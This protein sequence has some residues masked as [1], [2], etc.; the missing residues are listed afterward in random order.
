MNSG[1]RRSRCSRAA[2][3]TPGPVRSTRRSSVT[4]R[5]CTCSSPA[6]TGSIYRAS[7]PIGNFPGSFGSNY[8]TIMSDTQANL[9]EARGGLQGQG[10]EPVPDDR[11]GDG[12]AAGGTSARSR[13]PASAARGRRR[14]PA[15]A[16]RSRARPTAAR[17]GPTTS[18]TVTWSG[19]NPDQT[20]TIDPCNLQLLYQGRDPNVEP[21]LQQPALPAGSADP[22]AVVLSTSKGR[23]PNG[24]PALCASSPSGWEREGGLGS[25]EPASD[26][27]RSTIA[28]R[29][30]DAGP[31]HQPP[32]RA[33]RDSRGRGPRPAWSRSPA[34]R[35]PDAGGR[36]RWC[37]TPP[38]LRG[39]VT[40]PCARTGGVDVTESFCLWF[41]GSPPCECDRS[42][43]RSP[44]CPAVPP[45]APWTYDVV[46]PSLPQAA[47]G[48]VR[49]VLPQRGV[50]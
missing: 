45:A 48:R 14:P 37:R 34:P 5:T 9:F 31:I 19:T 32:R 50:P 11:R 27:P 10:S 15:R 40:H 7:M 38:R 35:C 18:A 12:L 47:H 46:R 39:V 36:H 23:P 6:T 22:A 13:P 21:Q 8:T 25:T 1:R 4:A 26:Q 44:R 16:T 30:H 3:P 17:R 33:L 29:R 43:C 24:G 41:A 2:S 20:K 49:A 42:H 28:S